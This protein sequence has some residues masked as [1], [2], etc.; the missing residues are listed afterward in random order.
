MKKAITENALIKRINR[1]L[2][3]DGEV[4]RT[5]RKDF[6]GGGPFYTVDTFTNTIQRWGMCWDNVMNM[7][8]ELGAIGQGEYVAE[9]LDRQTP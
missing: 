7:A 3:K 2:A 6:Q 1:K 5:A 8:Q 9:M 4:L